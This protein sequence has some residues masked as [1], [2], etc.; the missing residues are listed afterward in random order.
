VNA[1]LLRASELVRA[2]PGGADRI[3]YRGADLVGADLRGADLTGANLRGARL[4]GADLSSAD[5]TLADL[6]GADVRGSDLAGARL[7][8]SIF[9]VQSQ[10]ESA[11]GDRTTTVPPA[12]VR[13]SHW[14][15]D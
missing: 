1:L 8:E 15:S 13:P 2:D 3:D 10:L 6:T 14:R 7:A 9:C 12:L 5:L 4:V 11:R